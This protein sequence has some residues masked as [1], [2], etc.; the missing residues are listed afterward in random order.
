LDP[1]VTKELDQIRN[2]KKASIKLNAI[3]KKAYGEM[4]W[5]NGWDEGFIQHERQM[6]G[7]SCGVHVIEMAEQILKF[8]PTIPKE[9]LK[10]SNT[11]KKSDEKRVEIGVSILAA[12]DEL[13]KEAAK[14]IRSRSVS[15]RLKDSY[16]FD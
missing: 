7:K 16:I 13:K 6:D 9:I 11:E 4:E 14:D 10:F 1:I 3:F 12:E 15:L 8:F 5:L 2:T